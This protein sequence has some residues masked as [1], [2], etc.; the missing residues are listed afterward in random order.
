M[1]VSYWDLNV[2][3]GGPGKMWHTLSI[4]DWIKYKDIVIKLQMSVFNI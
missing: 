3:G 4:V 1:P 2:G